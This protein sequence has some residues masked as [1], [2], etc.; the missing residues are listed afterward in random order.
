M[1][2]EKWMDDLNQDP[3]LSSSDSIDEILKSVKKE[4]QRADETTDDSAPSPEERLPG[5]APELPRTAAGGEKFELHIPDVY[6]DLTRDE[7]AGEQIP[8]KKRLSAGW[9][10]FIYVTCVLIASAVL[11]IVGWKCADDVCALTKP[12]R[13]VTVTV[14]D[15]DSIDD[16]TKTLKREGLIEY[17][18]LFQFYCWLSHAEEKVDPG[19]Y[20][21]NSRYDYHALVS[22]MISTSANRATVTVTVPE[23]YDCE[24]I[25]ALLE[26]DG[27]CTKAALEDTA[28]DHAFDYEFLSGLE[29]GE[30]NRLEGYLFPDTYEFYVGEEPVNVLDKFLK[31]FDKKFDSEMR[32]AIDDLNASL[33]EKMKAEG[34]SDGE[35]AD[36]MMDLHKVVTVASLIEKETASTSESTTISSVIYN[37]LCSKTY[38]LLEIDATVLYALG[39]HKAELSTSDLMVDSPYNT[40]KYPGLP[41]GPI[42]NPG[43]SSLKAALYPEDTRYYFYALDTDGKHHFSETYEEHQEFLDELEAGNA[44]Q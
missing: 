19:T 33:R 5:P 1:S 7:E 6:T 37:R 25:F 29:Y 22:G 3:D 35:V 34:F 39:E 40:R 44:A 16:V 4:L 8:P 24:Q 32:A 15:T 30:N 10:V 31:N 13:E 17:P 20:T 21:L 36:G 2:D 41:I 9:R 23:G 42:A 27:V 26:K 11:A 18:W 43:I 14:S 28:A 38:P 12:D